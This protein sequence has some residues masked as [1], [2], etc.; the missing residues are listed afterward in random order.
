MSKT[1]QQEW[2]AQ[3]GRPGEFGSLIQIPIS[4][5]AGTGDTTLVA[6]TV[7][8]RIFIEKFELVPGASGRYALWSGAGDTRI[9]GD[10]QAN[11]GAQYVHTDLITHA[12][13][14]ALV[15][16]RPDSIA[17]SGTLTY[18]LV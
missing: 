3:L 2:S 17:I 15:L 9:S 7:S 12:D 14:T 18:R 8:R 1:L 16:N 6:A 5:A 10:N 11:G 13:N 4:I